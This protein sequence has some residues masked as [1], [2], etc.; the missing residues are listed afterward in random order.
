MAGKSFP[1]VSLDEEWEQMVS[2]FVVRMK[3]QSA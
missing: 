1:T 3:A 2:N